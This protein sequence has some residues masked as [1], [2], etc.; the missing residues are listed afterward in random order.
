MPDDPRRAA[1]LL[2]S[3][4]IG[5]SPR[6]NF[7]DIEAAIRTAVIHLDIGMDRELLICYF[8]CFEND[9]FESAEGRS[10]L[11]SIEIPLK[12][13][14]PYRIRIEGPS[15]GELNLAWGG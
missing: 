9:D 5:A 11:Q 2:W 1:L 6:D 12:D 13:S 7:V 4:M 14:E 15:N 8:T 3:P 10:F